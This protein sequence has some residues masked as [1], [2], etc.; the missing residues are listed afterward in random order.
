M[1]GIKNADPVYLG[2][3]PTSPMSLLEC[4]LAYSLSMP[5]LVIYGCVYAYESLLTAIRLYLESFIFCRPPS[6]LQ[7][8]AMAEAEDPLTW[9]AL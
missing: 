5:L 8:C 1:D 2:S 3:S 7:K 9:F 4:A 6:V